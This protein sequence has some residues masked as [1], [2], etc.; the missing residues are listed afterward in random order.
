VPSLFKVDEPAKVN[1]VTVLIA[2]DNAC[3]VFNGAVFVALDAFTASLWYLHNI[4][5]YLQLSLLQ[6]AH[7]RG[8]FTVF[9]FISVAEADFVLQIYAYEQLRKM[10]ADA[11]LPPDVDRESIEVI[12][13]ITFYIVFPQFK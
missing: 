9:K 6:L 12:M 4:C 10:F 1:T 8:R 3:C 7:F 5:N 2:L 11:K 13:T